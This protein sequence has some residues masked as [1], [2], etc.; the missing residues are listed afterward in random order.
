MGCRG[1]NTVEE[2]IVGERV[3]DIRKQGIIKREEG[4]ELTT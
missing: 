1:A 3:R 2:L 4:R